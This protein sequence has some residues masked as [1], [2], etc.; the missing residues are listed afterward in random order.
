[1]KENTAQTQPAARLV[2]VA[3]SIARHLPKGSAQLGRSLDKSASRVMLMSLRG[4]LGR[5]SMA[6]KAR[7]CVQR[8][9]DIAHF[10]G[11]RVERDIPGEVAGSPGA[12][13]WGQ[14]AENIAQVD[15]IIV[16]DDVSNGVPLS[17]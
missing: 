15:M 6:A 10:A 5:P 7:T 13:C 17:A 16:T 9:F 8:V 11:L 3:I 2:S 12:K 4:E 14:A 1:M